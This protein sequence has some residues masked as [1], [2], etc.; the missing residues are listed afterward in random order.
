MER[1]QGKQEHISEQRS[2]LSIEAGEVLK[3]TGVT[4]LVDD[5]LTRVLWR[6]SIRS[7][8]DDLDGQNVPVQLIQ[9]DT[10]TP[11]LT[12]QL[13]RCANTDILGTIMV[14]SPCISSAWRNGKIPEALQQLAEKK[15]V[16]IVSLL[17]LGYRHRTAL[18]S[19]DIR[20]AYVA[21]RGVSALLANNTQLNYHAQQAFQIK[22]HQLIYGK[23][24]F[25]LV[26]PILG[27]NEESMS[28]YAEIISGKSE[29]SIAA[30]HF[31]LAKI[32]RIHELR[33]Q[34]NENQPQMDPVGRVRMFRATTFGE[35]HELA[36]IL[37][38]V[39]LDDIDV[40]RA[41]QEKMLPNSTESD[42]ALVALG[43]LLRI[44]SEKNGIPSFDFLDGVRDIYL[45][46]LPRL[47]KQY[48]FKNRH[49]YAC[50]KI[51]QGVR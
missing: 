10:T 37:A 29:L 6:Q 20:R 45:Q 27:L 16:A 17:D 11:E 43:G 30:V 39:P 49:W 44:T 24:R 41:I 42:F 8:L 14:L 21:P 7:F 50:K 31:D 46:A 38:A 22:E 35:A 28:R 2:L 51:L 4:I 40:V 25:T 15:N 48:A 36:R 3:Q 5:D 33:Q 19:G 13:Y 32:A 34:E 9:P 47:D 23:D 12:D 18:G 1:I 26:T